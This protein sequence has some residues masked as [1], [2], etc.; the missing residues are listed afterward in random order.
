MIHNRPLFN[1]SVGPQRIDG[2]LLSSPKA[3]L[4]GSLGLGGP[5]LDGEAKSRVSPTW[6]ASGSAQAHLPILDVPRRVYSLDEAHAYCEQFLR[7]RHE[8]LPVASRMLPTVMRPHVMALYAFARAADDF[9]DERVFAGK[10]H[11]ALEQWEHALFRTFHG[12]AD[13]PIFV[14]LRD[15]IERFDLPL[16]PFQELLVGCR[17]ELSPQPFPTFSDL[18]TYCRYNSEPL[19]ALILTLFGHR[20]ARRQRCGA[21]LSAALQLTSFLQDLGMD[22]VRG[23]VYVPMEDLVHFEVDQA[24]ISSLAGS[25]G[26]TA[27][28]DAPDEQRVA[29]QDLLRFQTARARALFERGRPLLALVGSELSFELALT[30]HSG[31]SLLDRIDS[32]GDALV[33]TRPTLSRAEQAKTL[34]KAL[35]PRWQ[36]VI[37]RSSAGWLG[38]DTL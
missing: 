5:R 2:A 16:L 26:A 36:E 33:Q 30:Y 11:F 32:L 23:R 13:H 6:Q 34:A 27:W 4:L 15:T 1:G 14:A 17:M 19:G 29:M 35:G 25:N 38:L 37:G 12:E 3:S 7:E 28:S 21:E 22:L 24:L 8:Q 20:D 31:L 10:R 9:A 18:R